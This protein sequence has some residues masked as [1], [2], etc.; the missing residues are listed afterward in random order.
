MK[1]S[2]N[3]AQNYSNVDLKAIP[4]DELLRRIG[5]QLG[6]VESAIDWGPR[7]QEALIVKVIT[8]EPHPDADKLRVCLIDD[9]KKFLNIDRDDN[10]LVRVV[11]GAPNARAGMYAVWLPPGA[12]VPSSL[13]IEPFILEAREIRGVL[14]NGMLASGKELGIND[15]HSGILEVLGSEVGH[16]PVPGEGL[17]DYFGL[18]DF[19]IDCENKMFTHRPDCFGILGVAREFAAISGLAFTSPTWYT[20]PPV[21]E[22]KA[23]LPLQVKNDV[24]ALVPR[25]MTVVMDNVSVR[26]SPVW[27]QAFLTRVGTK[28]INNVV[29]VTNFVMHLTGQPLHAFDYDKLKVDSNVPSLQPRLAEKNERLTILG[30]RQLTLSGE[31]LVIATDNKAVGLAGL[32]G[33]ADTE[34]DANTTTIVLEVATFD[35]YNIR[36]TS[37]RH[38]IF[39]E[40][41]TRFT[42]GQSPLQ[43]D[44]VLAYA[45][46]ELTR[47]SG[48][49][50][51]GVV[52]DEGSFERTKDAIMIE[53]SFV[54]ERLGLKLEGADMATLLKKAE[55]FVEAGKALTVTPPFW[56]MDIERPEDI[57]EEIGRLHGY[58]KLPVALPKRAAKAI[59]KNALRL[60]KQATRH[61]LSAAGA[62]E[63]LSYSFVPGDLLKKTGIVAEEA[64]Y[65]LRNALSPDLQYYRPSLTPSLLARVHPNIKAQAGSRDNHFAIFEIGRAHIKG[66]LDEFHLPEQMEHLA[67]IVAA[68]DK[69]AHA[70]HFGAAYFLARKYLQLLTQGQET[71]TVLEAFQTLPATAPFMP[72]RSGIITLENERIGII[73]EYNL[74]AQR[75]LKLPA[76]TSGFEVDLERL[77]NLLPASRYQPLSPFPKL[78]QDITLEVA[79]EMPYEKVVKALKATAKSEASD[80][81]VSIQPQDIFRADGTDTRRLTFRITMAHHH[82]TLTTEEARNILVALGAA[83]KAV[84]NAKVI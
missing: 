62:N 49:Q 24:P 46:G 15:D 41:A 77:K 80:L 79:A 71:I 17:A 20:E 8:C 63:V 21:F 42:K 75:A 22:N 56:R 16:E 27:L 34:V 70:H 3:L 29:D 59:T 10:D 43:N 18:D 54:N 57:V 35:M 45:M 53:P 2:L 19:V 60:F 55:F 31:E 67:L 66:Q 78:Q 81:R 26:P 39:T 37:M 68:D 50:Q 6:A 30:G 61:K 5:A 1:V 11:C 12:T 13:E 74:S 23:T 73:G 72:G 47:Y 36:R 25:F 14:S 84:C 83:A 76:F 28:P 4:R 52:S 65:H 69:T 33:G 38:G 32:M 58:D 48:A 9:G 64:A 44:R 40:A 82:R 51:A 7:Y